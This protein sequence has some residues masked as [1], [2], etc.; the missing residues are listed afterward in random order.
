MNRNDFIWLVL[1]IALVGGGVWMLQNDNYPIRQGLDL[2]G[3][4]QVLLAADLPPDAEISRE[5]M[6]TSRQIIDQRVNAIGVTE[7]TGAVA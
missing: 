4:L 3:G 5:E 2:Q 6:E 1:I 7:T